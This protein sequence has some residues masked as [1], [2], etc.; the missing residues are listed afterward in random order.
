LPLAG[1]FRMDISIVPKS[2]RERDGGT[3]LDGHEGRA[4]GSPLHILILPRPYG[5]R[6]FCKIL[7]VF[8]TFANRRVVVEEKFDDG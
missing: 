3:E 7:R 6:S 5:L 1:A 8:Q 4:Q 2:V